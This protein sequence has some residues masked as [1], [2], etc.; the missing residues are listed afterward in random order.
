MYLKD[1]TVS[2][3]LCARGAIRLSSTY[4]VSRKADP[5]CTVRGL[6]GREISEEHLQ[7]SSNDKKEKAVQT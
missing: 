2:G 6:L 7:G 4:Y 3:L 5:V 1:S